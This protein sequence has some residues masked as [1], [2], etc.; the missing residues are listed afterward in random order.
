MCETLH[1]ACY[2]KCTNGLKGFNEEN[3]FAGSQHTL[4]WIQ[5][6]EVF[7][8]RGTLLRQAKSNGWKYLSA[9]MNPS[10]RG[11]TGEDLGEGGGGGREGGR[12]EGEEEGGRGEER[13]GGEGGEGG[14]GRGRESV[15]RREGGNNMTLNTF[16][17]NCH[18]VH[19]SFPVVS[20]LTFRSVII[21]TL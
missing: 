3:H 9:S 13:E 1:S 16:S 17:T 7:M 18:T 12:E 2:Q 5:S 6:R 11:K 15:G 21:K 4:T 14:S 8:I 10:G 20:Y 19:F